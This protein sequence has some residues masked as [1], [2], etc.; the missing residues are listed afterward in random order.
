MTAMQMQEKRMFKVIS[1]VERKDKTT[2]W[3][4]IGTGFPNRDG[5]INLY[6]DAMPIHPKLQLREVTEEERFENA[7]RRRNGLDGVG[8]DPPRYSASADS[9]PTSQDALPF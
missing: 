3:M 4:K 9:A 5:S 7:R 6:L 8:G 1:F 2:Y